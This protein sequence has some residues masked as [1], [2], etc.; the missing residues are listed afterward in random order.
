MPAAC[1]RQPFSMSLRGRQ[2]ARVWLRRRKSWVRRPRI[3]LCHCK[4]APSI[5]MPRPPRLARAVCT[6]CEAARARS[7]RWHLKVREGCLL[8]MTRRKMW[9]LVKIPKH[10]MLRSD[11][12]V[13][14]DKPLPIPVLSPPSFRMMVVSHTII[15]KGRVVRPMRDVL[16]IG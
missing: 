8:P 14:F 15:R 6:R 12:L 5:P 13:Q 10:S 3:L 11:S 1:N 2:H 9:F 7:R 4:L 16:G